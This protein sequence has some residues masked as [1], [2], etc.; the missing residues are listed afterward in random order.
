MEEIDVLLKGY[1]FVSMVLNAICQGS[2]SKVAHD[3][4]F[5]VISII[6]MNM[7]QSPN[8]FSIFTINYVHQLNLKPYR[9]MCKALAFLVKLKKRLQV[10]D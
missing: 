7:V 5:T 10:V 1:L 8:M 4:D 9:F 6:I 3:G 2:T